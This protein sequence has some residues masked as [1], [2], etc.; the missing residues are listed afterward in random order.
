[1]CSS[2]FCFY[3]GYIIPLRLCI[4]LCSTVNHSA[5]SAHIRTR[6]W[7]R[8]IPIYCVKML[9]NPIRLWTTTSRKAPLIGRFRRVWICT[10]WLSNRRSNTVRFRSS[11]FPCGI[12]LINH[13]RQPDDRFHASPRRKMNG[14]NSS[15]LKIGKFFVFE[16]LSR[17]Y[18]GVFQVA[19]R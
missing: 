4:P 5:H 3:I 14:R 17:R 2:V 13:R 15:T 1:M 16:V 8:K 9:V 18:T 11:L 12:T 6:F 10:L 7:R 19:K